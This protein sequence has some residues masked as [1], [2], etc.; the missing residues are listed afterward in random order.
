MVNY[1]SGGLAELVP[2]PSE[3]TYFYLRKWFSGTGSVGIAMQLLAMPYR[4]VDLP[5]VELINKELLVNLKSE[6]LTLYADTVF[7]YRNQ[8]NI[9]T[10]PTLQVNF[11]KIFNPICIVNTCKLVFVQSKWIANQANTIKKVTELV[12]L[13]PSMNEETSLEKV[14]E[15]MKN[16]VWPSVIATGLISEFYSQLLSNEVKGNMSSINNYISEE[17]SEKDW[18][19]RSIADQQKVKNRELTFAA[20]IKEYG[21]RSDKDYELTSP[22]W[23]E[24]EP[25]IKRRIKSTT[26]HKNRAA[27]ELNV[28]VKIESLINT[29]ITLQLLR[30]KAKQKTLI[31]IDKLRKLTNKSKNEK[32]VV[33]KSKQQKAFLSYGKGTAASQG[34][35]TGSVMNIVNNSVKIPSGTIGIFPNASPEFTFQYPK[36]A[37][38]IFLRGGATSHGSI[39]AREFGIPA[40]VEPS[41]SDIPNKQLI[42]IDG[43]TGEWHI[44]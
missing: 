25:E 1:Y 8:K 39:V 42:Q 35:V 5:I 41:A 33:L 13:I 23:Y 30:T 24:M 32:G 26:E 9:H 36:C 14:E 18:F 28:D 40:I 16:K 12:D 11:K 27:T 34:I 21:L 15:L 2:A 44:R 31:H 29:C 4:K 7:S 22:R 20:Y 17:L 6:E 19:F 3:L 38:I 10:T 37:G 43:T